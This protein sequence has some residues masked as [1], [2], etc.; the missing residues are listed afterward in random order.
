MPHEAA[1]TGS[2]IPVARKKGHEPFVCLPHFC[3]FP[4]TMGFTP[5]V[6]IHA[7][8]IRWNVEGGVSLSSENMA[9]KSRS[10]ISAP[11]VHLKLFDMESE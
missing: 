9:K 5:E 10:K 2:C 7:G 11:F 1:V 4:P 6:A 3:F 8:N